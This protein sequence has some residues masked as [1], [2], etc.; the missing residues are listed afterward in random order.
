MRQQND[1]FADHWSSAIELPDA[2]IAYFPHFLNT[3][4][5]DRL[6]QQLQQETP[7]QQES[8]R[9]AGLMRQQPRL[10]AWVGDPEAY[11]SYSG[12]QLQPRP[13]TDALSHLKQVLDNQCQTRFNSVLLNLYR[14][15]NDA[16]GWHSDD[17]KELG[18][19]PI[20]ASVSVGATRRFQLKHRTRRAYRFELAL[21]HG[22]LLIMAGSTQHHWQHAIPREK[23]ACPARINL[24]FRRI[25]R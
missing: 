12:L 1:L 18:M 11:Y 6:F 19:H 5:A 13:W 21:T 25:I 10:S 4:D 22:S 16:M 17:E 9:I 15:H 23:H 8:I 24:T 3:N 7:W 2:S 20:I 14:D